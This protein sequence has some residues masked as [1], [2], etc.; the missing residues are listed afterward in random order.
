MGNAVHERRL[1]DRVRQSVSALTSRWDLEPVEIHDNV[2]GEK[3]K[4]CRAVV[5]GAAEAGLRP[6]EKRRMRLTL[7][8]IGKR[9][10]PRT[11]SVHGSLATA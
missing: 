1:E 4:S 11:S 6:E 2:A 3:A 10:R 5:L 9:L 7:H 8:C